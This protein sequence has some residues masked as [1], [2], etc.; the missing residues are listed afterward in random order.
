MDD[1]DSEEVLTLETVKKL[2]WGGKKQEDEEAPV[3]WSQYDKFDETNTCSDYNYNGAGD[4]KVC[5]S[6]SD[7]DVRDD[8]DGRCITAVDH[9][10]D[11]D[12]DSTAAANSPTRR[13]RKIL[14]DSP[15]H[16]RR[17]RLKTAVLSIGK[18]FDEQLHLS[19]AA[20]TNISSSLSESVKELQRNV[21]LVEERYKE[22]QMRK[23]CRYDST[24]PSEPDPAEG[25]V[26]IEDTEVTTDDGVALVSSSMYISKNQYVPEDVIVSVEVTADANGGVGRVKNDVDIAE[27]AKEFV[28]E[29][30]KKT[31]PSSIKDVTDD[32][33]LTLEVLVNLA[34]PENIDARRWNAGLCNLSWLPMPEIRTAKLGAIVSLCSRSKKRIY[35]GKQ[36]FIKN[37][38]NL[39]G[40]NDT[41]DDSDPDAVKK[42]ATELSESI[43]KTVLLVLERQGDWC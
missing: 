2:K 34:I 9:Q 36:Q 39:H 13:L 6:G 3:S 7:C 11:K 40:M 5:T 35:I 28:M 23:V 10:K 20:V 42:M 4:N 25:S 31:F 18:K 43:A 27:E 33:V 32:D 22:D 19:E 15:S 14:L 12:D 17:H 8:D 41:S 29:E 1:E 30:L 26:L 21:A 16:H 37:G 38:K 24:T